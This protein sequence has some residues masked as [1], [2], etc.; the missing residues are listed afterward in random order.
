M[1]MIQ[2]T[3]KLFIGAKTEISD[4]LD[5]KFS[6]TLINQSDMKSEGENVSWENNNETIWRNI[7]ELTRMFDSLTI[8]RSS[9]FQF[10]LFNKKSKKNVEIEKENSIMKVQLK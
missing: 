3:N 10:E 7:D 9:I 6:N 2:I 5:L 8:F 1:F 4:A